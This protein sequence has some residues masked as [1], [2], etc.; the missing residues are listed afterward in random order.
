MYLITVKELGGI[1]FLRNEWMVPLH[2]NPISQNS[3]YGLF[4]DL[5]WSCISTRLCGKFKILNSILTV[6]LRGYVIL[7]SME[8][9]NLKFKFNDLISVYNKT[10]NYVMLIMKWSLYCIIGHWGQSGEFATK[11][12]DSWLQGRTNRGVSQLSF[13]KLFPKEKSCSCFKQKNFLKRYMQ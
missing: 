4:N 1:I 10:N 13:Q 7:P 5:L 2:S 12:N 9:Q 3:R 6:V 8:C 11:L